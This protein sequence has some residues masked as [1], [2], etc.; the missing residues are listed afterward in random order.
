MQ[1][2]CNLKRRQPRAPPLLRNR[3]CSRFQID[4]LNRWSTNLFSSIRQIIKRDNLTPTSRQKTRTEM[5][6]SGKRLEGK[7]SAN[8]LTKRSASAMDGTLWSTIAYATH[9]GHTRSQNQLAPTVH[10]SRGQAT[11]VL[12]RCGKSIERYWFAQSYRPALA[13]CCP[14]VAYT[15]RNRRSAR[16]IR[17]QVNNDVRIF[18]NST[19]AYMLY[20]LEMM[21]KSS[22]TVC[23]WVKHSI[24]YKERQETLAGRWDRKRR[25]YFPTNPARCVQK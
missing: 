23:F 10:P 13:L 17:P 3:K 8:R 15:G 16:L 6:T 22:S 25:G 9:H 14:K 5:T 21:Q 11:D 7:A 24:N 2:R 20:D 12:L 4:P 19:V 18:P 1:V